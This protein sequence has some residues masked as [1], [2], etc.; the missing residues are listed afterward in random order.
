MS[1]VE[2]EGVEAQEWA[3]IKNTPKLYIHNTMRRLF[4]AND[5]H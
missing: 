2:T 4:M 3:T 1:G 5:V